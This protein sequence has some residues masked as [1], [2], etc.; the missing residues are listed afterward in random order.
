VALVEERLAARVLPG[1]RHPRWGTR[2]AILPVGPTCYLEIIGPGRPGE[3][4]ALF[5][6]GDLK[7]P[8][9]VTWAARSDDLALT[10]V[11]AAALD[12]RLG[13]RQAGQRIGGDGRAL[14]WELTDPMA[15]RAGGVIPFFI[16]LKESRHPASDREPGGPELIALTA[17]HPEA[18]KV[19]QQLE[20]LFVPLAVTPGPLPGMG[21]SF[22]VR[23]ATVHLS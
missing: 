8:R 18:E 6:I 14:S 23:G 21:A 10:L 13:A 2:N 4:P 19:A 16:D 7:E 3:R 5:G 9:L 12:I 20:A 11:Q 15:D 17:E 1:G 22:R